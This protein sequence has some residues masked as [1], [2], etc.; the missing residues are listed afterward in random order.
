MCVWGG[1]C[2]PG[3]WAHPQEVSSK[4]EEK[5]NCPIEGYWGG[6][7][8][9]LYT[10]LPSTALYDERWSFNKMSTHVMSLLTKGRQV[11][12]A[13]SNL[14]RE[15]DA[16]FSTFIFF[17]DL[18]PSGPLTRKI[19]NSN[20]LRCKHR[21]RLLGVNHIGESYS[22]VWIILQGH[23]PWCESYCGV[24]LRGVNHIAESYS[25]V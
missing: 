17:H 7:H 14:E 12:C 1:G 5:K 2:Q 6:L 11:W 3:F 4:C 20:Q 13:L 16:R 25:A 23:T 22:A 15:C 9:T 8:S 10:V 18:N 19:K 21:D 24:I